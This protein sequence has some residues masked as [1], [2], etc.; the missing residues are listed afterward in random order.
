MSRISSSSV[1]LNAVPSECEVYLDRRTVPGETEDTIKAD[2]D[3]I[4]EG[5]DATWEIGTIYRKSWTGMDIKYEPLHLA[6]ETDLN[7]ELSKACIDAYSEYFEDAPEFD[8]WDFSTNAVTPVSM[9][10]PSIGFGPGVYKLAH[11]RNEKC[12]TSKIID[13]CGFY[14]ALIHKLCSEDK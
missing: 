4:I 9:G 11:C 6:W 8:Y 12:E 13:A 1:S 10:I 14:T 7:H 5:K 2:M 3:K